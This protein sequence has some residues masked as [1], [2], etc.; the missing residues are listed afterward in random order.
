MEQQKSNRPRA[1]VI[2]GPNGAG[3]TTCAAMLLPVDID[4]RRFVNADVIASGLSA[5]APETV[6]MQ[7]GR[8]LLARNA[9]L[10]RQRQDFAFEA[11]LA[12]R[13]FVPFLTRDQVRYDQ[14]ERALRGR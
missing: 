7:A 1:V 9:D 8:I 6:A 5:F 10:A 3:K 13:S 12:S 2:G 4:V 14:F 11:T